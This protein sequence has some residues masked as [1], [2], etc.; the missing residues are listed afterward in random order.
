MLSSSQSGMKAGSSPDCGSSPSASRRY[1]VGDEIDLRVR[2][3]ALSTDPEFPYLTEVVGDGTYGNDMTQAELDAGKLVP[4][5]IKVG[6]RVRLRSGTGVPGTVKALVDGGW[7]AV[8][9]D[10]E[11]RHYY[12]VAPLSELVRVSS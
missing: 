3:I 7:A 8:K 2:V 9:W 4:R 10:V 6:D 12:T 1:E 11:W 5:P